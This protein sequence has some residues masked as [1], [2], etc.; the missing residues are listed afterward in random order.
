MALTLVPTPIGNS[1]DFSLRAI[2]CL[3]NAEIIILEER[4][5]STVWLRAIGIT[6]KT[7]ETLN[8]HSTREDVKHLADLCAERDC[9]LITDCGTPGFCDPGADL[10]KEC[11]T[12]RIPV[13]AL[14]GPSS[15]MTLLSLSSERLDQFVFRGFLPVKAEE[16]DQAWKELAAETKATVVLETP[17]R[18]GKWLAECA[19]FLPERKVLMAI[20]L[21]QESELIVEA[22]GK[23]LQDKVPAGKAEFIALIYP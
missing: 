20:N 16:R 3:K 6:G 15:L 18:M 5:E 11:R 9:A 1:D 22:L 17:Y 19:R 14:P 7:Y 21:T 12:R 13:K 2:E 4:K 23:H 8:E 10:V